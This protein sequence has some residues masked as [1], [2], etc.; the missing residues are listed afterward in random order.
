MKFINNIKNLLGKIGVSKKVEKKEKRVEL[1][2]EELDLEIKESGYFS[3]FLLILQDDH[4]NNLQII[5]NKVCSGEKGAN[6]TEEV[7]LLLGERAKESWSLERDR[8]AYYLI[9]FEEYGTYQVRNESFWLPEEEECIGDCIRIY[10]KSRFLE[11][12]RTVSFI[13]DILGEVKHYQIGCENNII[14]VI[15]HIEPKIYKITEE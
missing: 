10:S 14:D 8:T 3:V 6:L 1:S 2:L 4:D 9:D 15:S 7:E 5:V 12:N 13:E 11:Y